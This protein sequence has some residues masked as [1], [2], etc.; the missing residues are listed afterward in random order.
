VWEPRIQEARSVASRESSPYFLYIDSHWR[1]LIAELTPDARRIHR[2]Y[3]QKL[4]RVEAE[5][6]DLGNA[7][8]EIAAAVREFTCGTQPFGPD[9]V[10]EDPKDLPLPTAQSMQRFY[11]MHPEQAPKE[12]APAQE[13][14]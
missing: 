6:R 13:G 11:A 7:R 1:E 5:L 10:S 4:A 3:T 14:V 2:E 8:H 9:V 12:P